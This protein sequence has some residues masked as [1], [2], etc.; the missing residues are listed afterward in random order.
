MVSSPV[1]FLLAA[2]GWSNGALDAAVLVERLAEYARL[3][4]RA[5]PVDLDQALL[6]A[7]LPEPAQRAGLAAEAAAVST[8]TSQTAQQARRLRDARTAGV[9][10]LR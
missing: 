3:G 4:L 2:P 1:P 5:G 8:A 10:T 6:R 7:C 9:V